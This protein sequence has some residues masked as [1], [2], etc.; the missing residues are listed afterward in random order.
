MKLVSLTVKLLVPMWMSLL[1][2][3]G[4]HGQFLWKFYI[5]HSLFQ[6]CINLG[7]WPISLEVLWEMHQVESVHEMQGKKQMIL[8]KFLGLIFKGKLFYQKIQQ[9]SICN[10]KDEELEMGGGGAFVPNKKVKPNIETDDGITPL[11]SVVAAGSLPCLEMLIQGKTHNLEQENGVKEFL[12][13]AN[14]EKAV[15]ETV[16]QPNVDGIKDQ[17]VEVS[18]AIEV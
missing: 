5:A 1:P 14:L 12:R 13:V 8:Y 15:K 6:W 11:L 18:Q 7:I 17:V 9:S 4:N 2:N 16:E 3:I 10:K